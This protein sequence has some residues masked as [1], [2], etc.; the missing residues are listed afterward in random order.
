FPD[1]R[2]KSTIQK[3]TLGICR[4]DLHRHGLC[5][6]LV[7]VQRANHRCDICNERHRTEECPSSY[8]RLLSL[9]CSACLHFEFLCLAHP[10]DA[11]T[12]QQHHASRRCHNDSDASTSVLGPT[13]SDHHLA[14]AVLRRF[15]AVLIW[16]IYYS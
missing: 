5:R 6:G 10:L 11:E 7:A 13:D 12:F 14:A 3:Q 8:D 1:E 16:T 9:R 15:R 2:Q 4:A